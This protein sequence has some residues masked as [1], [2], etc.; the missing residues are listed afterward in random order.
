MEARPAYF[1]STLHLLRRRHGASRFARCRTEKTRQPVQS[2]KIQRSGNLLRQPARKIRAGIDGLVG[3]TRCPQRVGKIVRLRR[4]KSD[5]I[6]GEA[7]LPLT[8]ALGA[9][10]FAVFAFAR[11]RRKWLSCSR[12]PH[13]LIEIKRATTFGSH[14]SK[15]DLIPAVHPIYLI[16]FLSDTHRFAR[17]H[18]MDDFFVFGSWPAS[19]S[20][21][22][23]INSMPDV[24][25]S[26]GALL[27][28]EK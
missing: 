11:C 5:I 6:F 15:F 13:K 17:D 26:V 10:L 7:D 9:T 18:A 14:F 28:V 8:L 2:Q 27:E 20:A 24:V 4:Q 22:T 23:P 16:A 3:G 12:Q 21:P 19:H 25:V 1:R